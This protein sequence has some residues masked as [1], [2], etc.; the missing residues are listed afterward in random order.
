MLQ[1]KENRYFSVPAGKPFYD[2]TPY[3][4]L[5]KQKPEKTA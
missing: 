1:N 5:K 2:H 4:Y 3:Y